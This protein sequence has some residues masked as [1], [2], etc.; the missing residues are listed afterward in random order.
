LIYQD[1]PIGQKAANERLK[2]RQ[3]KDKVGE[4]TITNLL[5]QFRDNLVEIED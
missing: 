2:R 1:R 5:Q 4:V 3:E